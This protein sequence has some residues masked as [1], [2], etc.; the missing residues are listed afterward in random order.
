MHYCCLVFTE[1]IPDKN[2]LDEIMN[3]FNDDKVYF[4]ENGDELE[5]PNY[6]S[7]SWDWYEVGGRYNARIKMKLNESYKYLDERLN[8]EYLSMVVSGYMKGS[9]FPF[10]EQECYSALGY[11]D[12]YLRVDGCKIKDI[13][14]IDDIQGF[15]LVSDSGDSS[16]REFYDGENFIDTEKQYEQKRVEMLEKYKDGFLTIVDIH[17]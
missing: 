6:K 11:L 7:F 2:K 8:R 10:D 12:G 17:D 15:C 4:D 14:N 16:S 13:L 5:K 3:P 9:P 1:T